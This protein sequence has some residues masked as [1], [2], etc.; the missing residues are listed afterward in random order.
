MGVPPPSVAET[1][2]YVSSE[3]LYQT[4][5]RRLLIET[6]AY[7]D[8]TR[9]GARNS[10]T[11][12]SALQ[13]N[14]NRSVRCLFRVWNQVN[15][16]AKYPILPVNCVARQGNTYFREGIMYFKTSPTQFRE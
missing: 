14:K 11:R 6:V 5:Y 13:G 2:I 9:V 8:G 12:S 3:A 1:P 16:T 15:G 10:C 4:R 7:P